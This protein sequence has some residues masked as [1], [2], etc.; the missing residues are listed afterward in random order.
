MS[1]EIFLGTSTDLSKE[2]NKDTHNI[3]T[4]VEL[5]N[6][7]TEYTPYMI[8]KW[9]SLFS[10]VKKNKLMEL[11]WKNIYNITEEIKSY[12]I[13]NHAPN[14]LPNIILKNNGKPFISQLTSIKEKLP[15]GHCILIPTMKEYQL[16][17][18][19]KIRQKSYNKLF[20]GNDELNKNK[21]LKWWSIMVNNQNLVM[22]KLIVYHK[23]LVS[24][25]YKVTID[26]VFTEFNNYNKQFYT[27]L[28]NRYPYL[29]KDIYDGSS[30]DISK[31]VYVQIPLYKC[32]TPKTIINDLIEKEK[33]ADLDEKE[34]LALNDIIAQ[35]K[36]D[37]TKNNSKYAVIV[38]TLKKKWKHQ[39]ILCN[40]KTKSII[41]R[42][43]CSTGNEPEGIYTTKWIFRIWDKFWEWSPIW[44]SWNGI[45]R[46]NE[47]RTSLP[48]SYDID[49]NPCRTPRNTNWASMSS[50]LMTL[51]IPAHIYFHGTNKIEQLW[52]FASH[53]CIR[54]KEYD[55]M[56]LFNLI[57]PWT[58]VNV[59][60]PSVYK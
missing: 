55:I 27:K 31:W 2:I 35:K 54:M 22:Q 47:N 11:S 56:E 18:E 5:L 42:Y 29:S 20:E 32:M 39:V 21:N 26:D 14:F 36:L 19:E 10:I 40:L 44:T 30:N 53:W 60:N 9:E 24:D 52:Y 37:K 3:H 12:N 57:P 8:G 6:S 23:S 34:K 38:N 7:N 45:V 46:H 50:R 58:Y 59:M 13:I 48:L 43:I 16:S 15:A 28:N 41:K 17:S 25:W 49:G 1:W 33:Y 4:N 51:N